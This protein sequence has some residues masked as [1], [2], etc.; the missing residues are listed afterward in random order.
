M[1]TRPA[2]NDVGPKVLGM[3]RSSMFLGTAATLVAPFAGVFAY[4]SWAPA[5]TPTQASH[6]AVAASL[7]DPTTGPVVRYRPCKRPARLEDGVCVTHRVQVVEAPPV[8]VAAPPAPVQH[9]PHPT[10]TP[11]GTTTP[12]PVHHLPTHVTDPADDPTGEAAGATQGPTPGPSGAPTCDP[13][14]DDEG[15]DGAAEGA[16]EDG[17]QHEGEDPGDEVGRGVGAG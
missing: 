3:R 7:G 1:L 5:P 16:C 12:H 9:A 15:G 6:R 13:S 17:E 10:Q 2:D 8:P 4:Q 11:G 14:P